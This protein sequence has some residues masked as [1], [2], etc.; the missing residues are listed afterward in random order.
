[1][2]LHPRQRADGDAEQERQLAL[3]EER[4]R[5][6]QLPIDQ[7]HRLPEIINEFAEEI[8]MVGLNP[9]KGM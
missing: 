3:E 7:F 4:V 2:P 6:E 1:M 8:D 5:L 9:F